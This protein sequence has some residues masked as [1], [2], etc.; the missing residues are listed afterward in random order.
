MS[1]I[2]V[3]TYAAMSPYEREAWK[4]TLRRLNRRRDNRMR[5]TARTL[6]APVKRVASGAWDRVPAHD[7]LESQ[8]MQAMAGMKAVTFD[9]ALRS[10]NASKVLARHG[11]GEQRE[12]LQIDLQRL[13]RSLPGFRTAFA[14]L[15]LVEGGGSALVVTGAQVSA[16]VSGGV[17]LAAAAAAMAAD[18]VT[19]MALMGRIIGQVAAE[20]G[21][22]V[23]LPEEEA[24]ALGVMSL[25]AAA[26]AAEK[27]AALAQLRRLTGVMMRQ[28]TWAELNRFA[29]V[30]VIDRVFAAL[31]EK[32]VKRKLAQAVPIAGVL[33]NAGLSAQ[34]ADSAYRSARDAYRLRFL[35]VKYGIDP[36]TWTAE[37]ESAATDEVLGAALDEI[38]D[39]MDHDDEHGT[40]R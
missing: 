36:A 5:T 21:Y 27:A 30:R 7:E 34:M 17:T 4:E 3:D 38:E 1:V 24:F 14:T 37:D 6:S 26:T 19:S 25:G 12:L 23:R 8:V 35:S 9:P 18:S 39:G 28:P 33:I 32:L 40:K 31:G 15:A 22:D 13:D 20:Y 29:L 10:V 2:E 11:V 16:T